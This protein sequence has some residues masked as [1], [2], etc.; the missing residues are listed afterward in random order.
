MTAALLHLPYIPNVIWLRNFLQ[1]K[2]IFIER[3]ENFVKSTYRNRC[4][5]AGANGKLLLSI[6][7]TGGRDHHQ[8]YQQVRIAND[9]GWQKKHWQTIRSAYGSAPY[10]E[11]YEQQFF[12]FYTRSFE[13]LFD[14]NLELLHTVLKILKT[15]KTFEFTAT[16]S[17]AYADKA[18]YRLKCNTEKALQLPR[19]YQ[20]FD[21]RN[22]FIS[23]LSC[24][25]LIFNLGPQAKDYLLELK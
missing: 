25:D 12:P 14:A 22:G 3:E 16:Y 2:E 4:E 6:P 8:L 15:V 17:P 20:V 13:F 18:D 10:F 9:T 11:F 21:E 23:N 5:I 7:V 24:L 19:Y 1:H